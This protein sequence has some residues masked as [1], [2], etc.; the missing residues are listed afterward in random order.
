P[1]TSRRRGFFRAFS[2]RDRKG[3]TAAAPEAPA[4][5]APVAADGSVERSARAAARPL[6]DDE[7]IPPYT[8][9]GP[10][11]RGGVTIGFDGLAMPPVRELAV[12][13]QM[14]PPA[15]AEDEQNDLA[16]A[17]VGAATARLPH[18]ADPFGGGGGTGGGNGGGALTPMDLIEADAGLGAGAAA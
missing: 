9:A 10:A 4:V 2:R 13:S 18:P 5:P 3:D 16:G 7:R 17:G 14:S 6:R 15:S 11:T 12:F 1:P 8:G